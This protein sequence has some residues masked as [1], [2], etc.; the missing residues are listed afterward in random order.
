MLRISKLTDYAI[1]IMSHMARRVACLYAATQLADAT[2]V[3]LPTVSKVLKILARAKLVKSTRGAKGGYELAQLP[4]KISVAS[5]ISALE[6]PIA[7]TE[8]GISHDH[9]QQSASCTLRGNWN[10][11]NTAV[12]TALASVTLADMIRPAAKL[13]AEVERPAQSIYLHQQR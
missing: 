4:D 8:C 6:G 12:K 7:L 1:I 13:P 9:C 3:A 11:I 10:P 5:I 2:G